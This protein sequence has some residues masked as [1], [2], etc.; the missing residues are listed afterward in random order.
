M[1]RHASRWFFAAAL[2]ATLCARFCGA[3]EVER[4]RWYIG[5][6]LGWTFF[7]K[8]RTF[9]NGKDLR[10]DLDYGVRTGVRLSVDEVEIALR[11]ETQG[12]D[13]AT[14][15]LAALRVAGYPLQV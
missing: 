6:N 4:R 10:N 14:A 12:P 13:H 7:D 9:D 1:H 11:L 15:V 5:P 8:E 3:E 2:V